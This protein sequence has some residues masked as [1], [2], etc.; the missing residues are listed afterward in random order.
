MW[1]VM[2]VLSGYE[3]R[4]AD[5]C[6]ERII[7][8][9]EE[10]FV[11]TYERKMKLRGEYQIVESKLFPGYVFLSTDDVTD[12]HIRLRKIE[13]LTKI[14]KTG[15]VFTPLNKDE[16]E[17]LRVVGGKDHRVT[18]SVGF[19]EGDKVVIT[20]G[21]LK[22]WSGMIKKINRHKRTAVIAGSFLGRST[23]ITVGLEIVSKT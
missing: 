17:W 10:V 13:K 18:F 16:E 21:A 23:D 19:I 11:P 5:E 20:S 2:Q 15:D 1:Y 8:P 4:V 7:R 12:F 22:G 14:L 9:D 6:R 3:L